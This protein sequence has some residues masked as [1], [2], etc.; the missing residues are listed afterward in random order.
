MILTLL[1]MSLDEQKVSYYIGTY[2][3]TD[4]MVQNDRSV[5]QDDRSVM[6]DQKR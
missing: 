1:K 3:S 2:G 4:I 5:L 6:Q